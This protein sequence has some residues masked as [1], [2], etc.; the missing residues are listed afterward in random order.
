[1][2]SILPFLS[3]LPFA[4][5]A[6][7]L[8]PQNVELIPGKYIVVMRPDAS[9]SALNNL[10]GLMGEDSTD[11][12]YTI[13]S[14]R[15]A[16]GSL[17]RGLMTAVQQMSSVSVALTPCLFTSME[18]TVLLCFPN[19]SRTSK[20]GWVNRVLAHTVRCWDELNS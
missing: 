10:T 9:D 13:G 8:T 14:F 16:A 7:L 1:M 4:A 20:K 12:V 19:R 2:R 6:P 18:C 5:A 3:V 15:A 11:Y 17:S